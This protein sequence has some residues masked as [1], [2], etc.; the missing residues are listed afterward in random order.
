MPTAGDLLPLPR[1]HCRHQW[2]IVISAISFVW[3][4]VALAAI[5]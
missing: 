2:L 4:F 3:F 1:P 5:A